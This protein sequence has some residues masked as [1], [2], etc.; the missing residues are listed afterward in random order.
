MLYLNDNF[1]L[2]HLEAQTVES[3]EL[4]KSKSLSFLLF[5]LNSMRFYWWSDYNLFKIINSRIKSGSSFL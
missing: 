5:I 1:F 4:I 3:Y 2:Y